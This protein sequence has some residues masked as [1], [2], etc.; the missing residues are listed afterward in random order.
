MIYTRRYIVFPVQRSLIGLAFSV[1]AL[2]ILSV[3]TIIGLKYGVNVNYSLAP[4]PGY[5][6][7]FGNYYRIFMTTMF[8]VL[9]LFSRF[10][11]INLFN[12]TIVL[13][14]SIIHQEK[15]KAKLEKL[16]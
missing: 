5:L 8:L 16:Q 13:I 10:F 6:E 11:L 7:T 9:M 15:S 12:I 3:S 4:P 2:L 1:K 14:N